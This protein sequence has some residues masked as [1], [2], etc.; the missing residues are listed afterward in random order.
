MIEKKC[1]QCGYLM[2]LEDNESYKKICKK[3]Y[4][5]RMADEGIPKEVEQARSLEMAILEVQTLQKECIDITEKNL[6][7]K[8]ESDGDK[9]MANT[10]FIYLAKMM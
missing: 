9:A 1:E 5:I 8:L 4:A 10:L 3:C 2:K 7:H 6:G